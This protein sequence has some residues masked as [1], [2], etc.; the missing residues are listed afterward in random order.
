MSLAL[1]TLGEVEIEA[2]SLPLFLVPGKTLAIPN[3][4][5]FFLCLS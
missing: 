4:M 3:E 5:P 2:G 1:P